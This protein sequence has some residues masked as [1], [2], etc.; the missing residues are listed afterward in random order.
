MMAESGPKE[1]RAGI[2]Y[3]VKL[4]VMNPT[5]K[6]VEYELSHPAPDGSILLVLDREGARSHLRHLSSRLMRSR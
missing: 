6:A 3:Q 4:M 5:N 1:L 2:P